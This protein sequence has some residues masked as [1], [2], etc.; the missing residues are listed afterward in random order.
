[1]C[2]GVCVRVCKASSKVVGI[3]N[4]SEHVD[5]SRLLTGTLRY[6][7]YKR[8]QAAMSPKDEPV[9]MIQT[10]AR[11]SARVCAVNSI[12]SP[13]MFEWIEFV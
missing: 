9:D 4:V 5:I 7:S 13:T 10:C 11:A 1:M 8:E 12:Y 3:F 6:E 2:V